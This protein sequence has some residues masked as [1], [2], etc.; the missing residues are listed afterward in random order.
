MKSQQP[1]PIM[2]AI[3][4]ITVAATEQARRIDEAIAHRAYEI[5]ERRGGM[6]WHELEDWRQAESE[7]RSKLCFGRTSSDDALLVACDIARF[8]ESSVEIWVAPRQLTICGRP[9][10]RK[11]K[12][13]GSYPYHGLVFRVV[14]LPAEVETGRVVTTVKHNFL[15]IHLPMVHS[16]QEG[17]ALAHAV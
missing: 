3:R 6:G 2:R 5:F 4:V 7:V 8:E 17:R 9:T 14:S 16:K 1:T 12:A 11:E 15:D 10:G 13:A